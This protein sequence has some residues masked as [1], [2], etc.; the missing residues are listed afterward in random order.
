MAQQGRI[1]ALLDS[2]LEH[3]SL[4]WRALEKLGEVA[5]AADDAGWPPETAGLDVGS[6]GYHF[7]AL[8]GYIK[9]AYDLIPR[10]SYESDG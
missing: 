1:E 7:A 8:L 2:A 9:R 4:A 3:G 6:A 5:E 10:T